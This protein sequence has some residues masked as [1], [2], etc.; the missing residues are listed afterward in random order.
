M[1]KAQVIWSVFV[2]ALTGAIVYLVWSHLKI[3]LANDHEVVLARTAQWKLHD[4]AIAMED[5]EIGARGYMLTSREQF[6]NNYRRARQ[7]MEMRLEEAALA[8]PGVG[9]QDEFTPISDLVH[10]RLKML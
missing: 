5:A 2:I 4:L 9:L 1:K 7:Q 8:V 6:L 3:Y 10:Q